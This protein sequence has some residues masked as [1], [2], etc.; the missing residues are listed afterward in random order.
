MYVVFLHKYSCIWYTYYN[1]N[2]NHIDNRTTRNKTA[3]DFMP[4]FK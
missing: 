2:K 4:Q 3:F 1:P